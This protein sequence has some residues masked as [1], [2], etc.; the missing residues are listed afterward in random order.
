MKSSFAKTLVVA[1]WK[2]YVKTLPEAKDLYGASVR[3]M[4]TLKRIET[5]LAM[6][7]VFVPHFAKRKNMGVGAQ[8]V[9][10]ATDGA[11]T[12]EVSARML[13]SVGATHV[14]IGHSE[15]RELAG[16]TDE[17]VAQKAKA[18]LS[19]GLGVV[20][21]VGERERASDGSSLAV[22]KRELLASLKGISRSLA[23]RLVIAYEPIWAISA[24][25]PKAVDTPENTLEMAI[26]IRK[27]LHDLYG[28]ATAS[29]VRVLYG[30]SVTPE[31]IRGFLERGGVDG[32][33]VGHASASAKKF[34][35]I[36]EEAETS[37]PKAL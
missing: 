26:Y 1:N 27:I 34:A 4:A 7:Y 32:V 10:W 28:K 17:I 15:R 29:R 18:G 21:C 6:P 30:G 25:H 3:A 14:I 8:D 19:A 33:L 2:L 24:H 35:R 23:A 12:G 20:L 13:A 37:Y 36:L 9:F 22:V 5:V 11:Y 31:N 16:D